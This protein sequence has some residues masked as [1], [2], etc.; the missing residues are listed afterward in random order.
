[1][2]ARRSQG[3]SFSSSSSSFRLRQRPG[4]GARLACEGDFERSATQEKSTAKAV[5]EHEARSDGF[6]GSARLCRIPC[7]LRYFATLKSDRQ[8]PLT[9]HLS[10]SNPPPMSDSS[11]EIRAGKLAPYGALPVP[12]LT[13]DLLS[14][15]KTG[16]VH[17]LAVIYGKE[18]PCRVQWR[19]TH[20]IL[21]FATVISRV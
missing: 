11:T 1:M 21:D 17:S 20:S 13:P 8:S 4:C 19:L 18:F 2:E 3:A 9:N 14:L 5:H 7:L 15:I 10:P 16:T 6:L 12:R